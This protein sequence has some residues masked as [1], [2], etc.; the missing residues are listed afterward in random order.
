VV[1]AATLIACLAELG[2]LGGKQIALLVGLAPVNWDSGEKR[3]QCHIKGGRAHVRCP[4]Y[5]A[6]V[7]AA[8]F[9]PDLKAFYRR[10]REA[11]KPAKVALTAV[12]RKLVVLAY[13]LIAENLTWVARAARSG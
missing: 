1:V 8:R 11:G 4:L 10:L 7:A 3:G 5:L 2:Q 6:A 9:N 12:A 13:T